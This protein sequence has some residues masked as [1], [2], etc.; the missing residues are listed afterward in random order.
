[1]AEAGAETSGAIRL[2]RTGAIG[3]V[4][5]DS[6]SQIANARGWRSWMAAY[7]QWVGDPNVYGALTRWI[8]PSPLRSLEVAEG[9]DELA[10]LYRLIWTIDRFS[11][12]NV[13]L[14]DGPVSW[15]DFCLVR[16]GTHK[17]VGERFELSFAV[18][19]DRCL[20]AGATWWLARLPDH[21]GELVALTGVTIDGA[22]SVA[23]GLA[24][25]RLSD[26]QFDRI[27]R[28]YASADPIDQVLDQLPVL[29]GGGDIARIPAPVVAAFGAPSY[30]GI[31]ANLAKIEHQMAG[32]VGGRLV[33]GHRVGAPDTVLRLVREARAM[34]LKETLERDFA[35][36]MT[37]AEGGTPEAWQD[38]RARAVAALALKPPPGVPEALG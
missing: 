23:L 27:E 11:K 36:A 16:H 7:E 25:H 3:R 24:T 35:T 30:D 5:V 14:I 20:D 18:T 31:V 32:A 37:R 34:T 8:D 17:V 19:G 33:S 26:S 28:A 22:D 13:A 2:E 4:L 6:E 15:A 12:P 1:M 9:L 21:L 29:T 10:E 38:H